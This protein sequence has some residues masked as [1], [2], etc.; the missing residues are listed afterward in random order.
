[1]S[2][3]R[4]VEALTRHL[5]DSMK[6]EAQQQL[7]CQP[8]SA[9]A[10]LQPPCPKAMYQFLVRDNL[11]LRQRI[12][13]FLKDPIYRPNYEL[14][15]EGF[16]DL[17]NQRVFK[18]FGARLFNI[19]DYTN[20]PLRFQAA[21][22][23]L[24]LCDYSLAIKSGVHATL[25]G[26][27][28]CKLGTEKHHRYYLPK[29][30]TLELPGCFAM[31]ELGHGSNVLGIETTATYDPATQEFVIN[32]PN[33]AASKF[34]IGGAAHTAKITACFANLIVNGRNEGIHVFVVPMR[35]ASS[36]HLPGV[37][38]ADLGAKQ[39]LNGV[40]NGQ[41]WFDHV[42]VPRDA[43]LDRFA[44]VDAAGNYHSAIPNPAQRFGT[45]IGG[46]TTGRML[47]GQGAVDAMKIGLTIAIR[48]SADR[49]Q[50]GDTP[51]IDYITQQRRLFPA[52]ATAYALHL[53]MVQLKQLAATGGPAAAKAVHVT[54]SG[55][56]AAATWH[57]VRV[58]QDCRETMGGMG[59]LSANRVGPMSND[60]N[61]DVTFEGD[62]TVMMQQ[63]AKPLLE[64]AA[65]RRAGPPALPSVKPEA[66]CL[67]CL[68][69]LLAFREALLTQQLLSDVAS[70]GGGARGFD[71]SLDTAVAL[72]W[73]AVDRQTFDT[74]ASEAEKAPVELRASLE[75]LARLYGLSRVE[76]GL[77][78]YLAS[79]ALPA[80]GPAAVRRQI[81]E[82]CRALGADRGRLALTLCDGFG[83]PDHLLAGE[84][85]VAQHDWR[86]FP[87]SQW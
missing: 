18:F 81:N 53:S 72:G 84:A 36:K 54:S 70:A 60:M 17:T 1:M 33:N 46:L 10:A 40:D 31:T 52:L 43:L 66:L 68:G 13:E 58:L 23:T 9:A 45:M 61:V 47:V 41:I 74:F 48:Y 26:G 32:T 44:Q 50:F 5:D 27:T 85:N 37:R 34:W 39:G 21:L 2:V 76:A 67:R 4:R 35:D 24:L 75:L 86:T 77:T 25:C 57:R 69:K 29:M 56:K 64:A 8:T 11:D 3:S 15:L 63:V 79:G 6:V 51:I 55:V 19:A 80:S 14:S 12:I 62:N 30:D 73:A 42:R 82:L 78:C 7:G 16:R 87:G 71:A 22:E 38:T 20:D 59:F 49:P 65:V 28:I 83:I